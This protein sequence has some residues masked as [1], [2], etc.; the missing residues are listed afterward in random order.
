MPL[1]SLRLQNFTAFA[2]LDLAFSPGVNI[3]VG[4]NGTGKTHVMKVCYAACEAS[5]PGAPPFHEKLMSVFL[6]SDHK[7]WRLINGPARREIFRNAG[8]RANAR[9]K[10]AVDICGDNLSMSMSLP[11]GKIRSVHSANEELFH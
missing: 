2:E 8:S 1:T 5:K 6:P 7:E 4:A 11:S 3:L 9:P 10:V